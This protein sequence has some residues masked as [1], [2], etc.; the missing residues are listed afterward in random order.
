MT[1]DLRVEEGARVR[2]GEIIARL[3]SQD[4]DAQVRRAQAQVQQAEAQI[5]SGRAATA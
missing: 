5:A 3:E 1:D 4:Y 2:E